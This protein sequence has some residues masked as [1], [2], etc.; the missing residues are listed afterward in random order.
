MK[1][2]KTV[3]FHQCY[4]RKLYNGVRKYG[5][6]ILIASTTRVVP[7]VR[8]QS[9]KCFKMTLHIVI[10][11]HMHVF[12]TLWIFIV[13]LSITTY[14]IAIATL[15]LHVWSTLIF[16]AITLIRIVD[17]KTN[18]AGKFLIFMRCKTYFLPYK[19]TSL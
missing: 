12:S 13:T 19:Y 1:N 2:H 14:M 4:E 17:N 15:P 11:L 10:T 3:F 5:H 16:L 6:C 7:E 8:R 18:L 9:L